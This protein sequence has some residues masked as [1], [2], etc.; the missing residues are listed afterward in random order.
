MST[1]IKLSSW[2]WHLRRRFIRCGFWW[3]TSYQANSQSPETLVSSSVPPSFALIM[4]PTPSSPPP[5]T[6]LIPD[7][8]ASCVHVYTFTALVDYRKRTLSSMSVKPLTGPR[9]SWTLQLGL[10]LKPWLQNVLLLTYKC[11]RARSTGTQ[12]PQISSPLTPTCPH[13]HLPPEC[14]CLSPDLLES[15]TCKCLHGP[16]VLRLKIHLFRWAFH[17]FLT[18]FSPLL[19]AHS[20]LESHVIVCLCNVVCV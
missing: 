7:T 17:T 2:L 5:T 15:S 8:N 16:C 12:P 19:P 4:S 18:S 6:L 11:L 9:M 10:R 14:F 1:V 20:Y 13:T 3:W